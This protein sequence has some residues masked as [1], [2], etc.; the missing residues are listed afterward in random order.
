MS[1]SSLTSHIN[2][3]QQSGTTND[4]ATLNKQRSKHL[5]DC[6]EKALMFIQICIVVYSLIITAIIGQFGQLMDKAR[7]TIRSSNTINAVK[8]QAIIR[9]A[10][11]NYY[12]TLFNTMQSISFNCSYFKELLLTGIR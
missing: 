11:N 2:N 7:S 4:T 6:T 3:E 8:Q 1:F 9:P 10:I 5:G 12:W